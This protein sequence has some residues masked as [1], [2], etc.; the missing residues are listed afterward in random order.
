MIFGYLIEIKLFLGRK[1]N[2]ANSTVSH[3]MNL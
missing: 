3:M 1:Y 2:Q